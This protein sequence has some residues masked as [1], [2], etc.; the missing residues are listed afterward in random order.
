MSCGTGWQTSGVFLAPAAAGMFED[1]KA[2]VSGAARVVSV[3]AAVLFTAG[4]GSR[5]VE[6]DDRT[7][8]NPAGSDRPTVHRCHRPRTPSRNGAAA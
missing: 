6:A 8:E 2:V 4:T 3:L 7:G 1:G 5:I